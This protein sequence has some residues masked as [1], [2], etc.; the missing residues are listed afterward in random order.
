MCFLKQCFKLFFIL[1]SPIVLA[2]EYVGNQSCAACHKTEVENWLPSHH[3]KA[4]QL[5]TEETVLGNFDDVRFETNDGWTKFF[6]DEQGFYIETGK[7]DEVGKRYSV[8]Y[9]FGYTPLQQI[10]IDIGSGRLQA[11][12]VAWDSRTKAK[13]GQRWYSLYQQTHTPDTPFY[14]KSQFNN[15][16][17]RCAECHSTD[18]K[19]GYDAAK[20]EYDTTWSEINVSCEACHGAAA[21]HVALKSADNAE[22]TDE[23]SANSGF[24]KTL[25]K[26]SNWIFKPE[27]ASAERLDNGLVSLD[28]GQ[29]DQCAACHSRRTALTDGAGPHNFSQ[30]F[31]PRLAVPDLYHADGQILDEVYVYG[32][33]SQ[34]KMAAA[35]VVC[36]NCHEPHSGK[37]LSAD[38]SLCV[39]CHL[40]NQFD[41]PEHTLHET[42]S[43]GALCI[44][45]HMPSQRYMG[46]DD[47]RDHSYRIP[48]PWVSEALAS[49]DVCLNCHQDKNTEW[50]QQQLE[51][52]KAKVFGAYDDIGSALYLNL[53][54]PTLGQQ[55]IA[56]LILD[57]EQPAM[58]RAVLL[59]HL[60]V[61][62]TSNLEVL[63]TAANSPQSLV[64]LGVL[65]A[66]ES[67]AYAMQLQIGFG[68]LYDEHKNVRLQ[69]IRL[70]APAFRQALPEKAQ[71]PMQDALMEAVLTYQGQQDLLSAQLALA[72]LA[73]KVGDLEQA[74]IQYLNAI[75]LQ[76]S[77][78]P[79]K[80]N[81]A[82]VYRESNQLE[83]AQV[84][85]QEILK[86]ES[87][88]P[89]AL[90]NLGLIYVVKRQW[91]KA[92]QALQKA[93]D[94][95][96]DNHRFA[97]VY[98]LALEASGNLEQAKKQLAKLEVMTPGDPAL[99][100]IR[101]RLK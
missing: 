7:S 45:C 88:H 27:Q 92:L 94:L 70:L 96:P 63:N 5:A 32:S 80:L 86:V 2:Q 73:Y 76:P 43:E 99:S 20:D 21:K 49:P 42:G 16:N 1:I 58:R 65:N 41:T 33:Y 31:I 57:E 12:T 68:L 10:L 15:W 78:L 22:N 11:Y 74:S 100:E 44:D 48:N 37:V 23:P 51:H 40:S 101:Q 14:W 46:V 6:R 30:H 19:R 36:S 66:L 29:V 97:Y 13:G 61:N 75:D 77:F 95:E 55:Q 69:A 25:L 4:M 47:R 35:G 93:A 53:Q 9:V 67:A 39:Q 91:A 89:M 54:D 98:L 60:D 85:L 24:D 83:K 72:D 90:H 62:I 3:A 26:R 56:S 79:A 71:Q 64:K 50:S 28:H 8:P 81:L 59:N 18:L 52:K 17:A 34:S 38:N 84:L 87:N 82:S